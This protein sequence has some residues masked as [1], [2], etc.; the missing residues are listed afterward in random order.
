MPLWITAAQPSVLEKSIYFDNGEKVSPLSR[1]PEEFSPK[2]RRCSRRMHR[3]CTRKPP[4]FLFVC[5]F[6]IPIERQDRSAVEEEAVGC[7]D[8]AVH[9]FVHGTSFRLNLRKRK[10]TQFNLMICFGYAVNNRT[11][12]PTATTTTTTK[13]D[14]KFCWFAPERVSRR[15]SPS[16]KCEKR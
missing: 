14:E 16:P 8:S 5:F 13:T 12:S 9:R 2:A 10:Y 1:R 15:R 6:S 4:C 11:K 7:A 3:T